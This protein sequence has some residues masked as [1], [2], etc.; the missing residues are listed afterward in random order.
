[1]ARLILSMKS[2]D[3]IRKLNAKFPIITDRMMKSFMRKL[4]G[5]MK[6]IVLSK[7]IQWRGDLYKS[8]RPK[9]LSKESYVI[10]GWSHGLMIDTMKSHTIYGNM[11]TEMGFKVAEWAKEKGMG[12]FV[13]D[14]KRRPWIHEGAMAGLK[15]G[16]LV[17]QKELSRGIKSVK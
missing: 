11:R 10:I 6:R 4:Q 13:I 9:R 7:K 8:I 2:N 17:L 3:G 12:S 14:V 5:E 15:K 1:M 16:G